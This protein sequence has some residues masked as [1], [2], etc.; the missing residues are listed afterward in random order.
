MYSLQTLCLYV[1]NA[2]NIDSSIKLFEICP[3]IEDLFLY[4][5]FSNINLDCFIHLKKLSLYGEMLDGFNFELFANICNQ[6]EELEISFNNM[7][8]ESIAK[9]LYGHNFPNISY[10]SISYSKIT[11]LEKKLFEGFPIFQSLSLKTHFRI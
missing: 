5:N 9:L 11:R 7:N 3:N 10:L 8:D 4:G 6:L 2:I 1:K